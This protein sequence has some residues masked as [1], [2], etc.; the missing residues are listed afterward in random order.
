MG[1]RRSTQSSASAFLK[2]ENCAPPNSFRTS[3][4][5]LARQRRVDADEVLRFRPALQSLLLRGQRLGIG[6]RLLD[7]LGD[8]VGVVGEVDARQIGGVRLRH[9]LGA[10]AQAHHARRRSGDH[11]LGLGK[12]DAVRVARLLDPRLEVVVELLRD[13]AR[14]LQVLLLVV[15][16]GHVRRAVGENVGRHQVGIDVEPDGGVLAVLAGLLLE[17]RHAVEPA[18]P[19]HAIED[20]GELGVLGDLAL[21]EEDRALG[22]E[23]GGDVGGRHLA[24]RGFELV[25][26][27]PDRDRVHVDDAVDALVRLLQLDPLQHGAQIVAEVQAAGRLHAGEDALLECHRFASLDRGALWRAGARRASPSRVAAQI[28]PGGARRLRKPRSC[29]RSRAPV[30]KTAST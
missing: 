24:D 23:P 20:P 30:A 7:L 15:A 11:R 18:E 9:L 16:D 6:L 3:A 29:R 17:L 27:L 13:V 21:V 8:R 19:R 5:G 2:V 28:G 10:V 14:Q 1:P 26:V 12:E 25:G 4:F 22:I